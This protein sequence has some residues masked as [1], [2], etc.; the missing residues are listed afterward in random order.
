MDAPNLARLSAL[1]GLQDKLAP[2]HPDFC[3]GV[4]RCP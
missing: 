3:C 1:D 4:C 2:V